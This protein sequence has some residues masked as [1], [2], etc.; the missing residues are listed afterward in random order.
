MSLM[1]VCRQF[2]DLGFGRSRRGSGGSTDI[3]SQ[4]DKPD[5]VRRLRFLMN[6]NAAGLAQYRMHKQ[7][8]PA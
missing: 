4:N 8:A 7:A 3:L 5:Q 1:L 6:S 2:C